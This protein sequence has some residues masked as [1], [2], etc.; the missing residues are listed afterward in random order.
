MI[1]F[2]GTYV[3]ITVYY[4]GSQ[5]VIVPFLIG[6]RTSSLSLGP[7]EHSTSGFSYD[8]LERRLSFEW[9]GWRHQYDWLSQLRALL[10]KLRT[11]WRDTTT[12]NISSVRGGGISSV[13]PELSRERAYRTVVYQWTI[14]RRFIVVQ[15]CLSSVATKAFGEPLSSKGGFVLLDYSG[16]QPSCHD[17]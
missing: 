1:G 3:T 13:R 9:T 17:I 16:V 8:W 10:L 11:N 6:L 14:P 15:T 7:A 5:S 12:S 4:N 2:I